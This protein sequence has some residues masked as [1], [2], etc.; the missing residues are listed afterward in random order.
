MDFIVRGTF[1]AGQKWERFTKKLTCPNK[2][3]ASERTYSLIGSEH[4]L[5]RNLIKIESIGE[6]KE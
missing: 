6:V 3:N 5:K 1:K 4:G 2:N